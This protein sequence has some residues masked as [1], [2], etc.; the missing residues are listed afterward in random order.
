MYRY[1]WVEVHQN[2]KVA[3]YIANADDATLGLIAQKKINCPTYIAGRD[4]E[5]LGT[6]GRFLPFMAAFV[7]AIGLIFLFKRRRPANS[8]VK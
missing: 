3:K 5:I 1:F 4:F 8:V 6:P 2:G 7:L